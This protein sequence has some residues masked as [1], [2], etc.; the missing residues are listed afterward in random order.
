MSKINLDKL[1]YRELVDLE[2]DVAKAIAVK[3]DT[4][5]AEMKAKLIALANEAGFSMDD[6]LGTKRGKKGAVT[7]AKYR[8]PADA[9]QTWTGRG[10]KPNW[11]VEALAAGKKLDSFAA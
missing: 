8:N 9:S 6:L 11:L 10:R 4:E 5:K 1:S 3:K 2:A 7:I